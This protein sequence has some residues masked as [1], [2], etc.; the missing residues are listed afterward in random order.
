MGVSS[1]SRPTSRWRPT[2]GSPSSPSRT[3]ISS[4]AARRPWST[5]SLE[6]VVGVTTAACRISAPSRRTRQPP[7]RV[8]MRVPRRLRPRRHRPQPRLV[9]PGPLALPDGAVASW[10]GRSGWPPAAG[11]AGRGGRGAGGA[12]GAAPRRGAARRGRGG[13]GPGPA[14]R[15]AWPSTT[16]SRP[17]TPPAAALEA[18]RAA[19]EARLPDLRWALA[20]G[21]GRLLRSPTVWE[22]AVK[23][24]LT[25]NCS[26]ALTRAM[27]ARLCEAAGEPGPGRRA[28]PSRR[29][30]RWRAAPSASSARRCG[31]AT[32][33]PSCGPWPGRWRRAALDLEAL[34]GGA[35][36]RPGELRQ[37]LLALDGF[38]P[39]AA[40]HL[41]RLLGRHDFL[42]LDSWTRDTLR[43]AAR[44]P[45]APDRGGRRAAGTR[46]TALTPGWRCGSR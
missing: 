38:G 21:A 5:P 44:P 18:P 16:T 32:G 39:Y 24:L 34:R 6:R 37:R 25:T 35:P 12:G 27:V 11:G 42:A 41:A 40:E 33:P 20:R 1:I 26:W 22:D 46:P 10:R 15:P 19:G 4:V 30:R 23:T 17:S 9:R 7:T 3:S 31:P 29:R 14:P 8:H 2:S 43:R 36:C 13:G 45:A 28:G